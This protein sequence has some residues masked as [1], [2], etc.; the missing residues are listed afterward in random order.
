MTKKYDVKT[1]VSAKLGP[2]GLWG[3]VNTKL[4]A[5]SHCVG[6]KTMQRRA[7]PPALRLPGLA[8]ADLT[9]GTDAESPVDVRALATTPLPP[10]AG[11]GRESRKLELPPLSGTTTTSPSTT[12]TTTT[13]LTQNEIK[14][15]QN[16]KSAKRFREAQKRRWQLL[17]SELERQKR[18]VEELRAALAA[19]EGKERVSITSLT[20]TVGGSNTNGNGGNDGINMTSADRVVEAEAAL[21]AQLLC[22]AAPV[23]GRPY[24][25]ELGQLHRCVLA[26]RDGVVRSTRRGAP[27]P[28]G[29]HLVHDVSALDAA[30]VRN[31]LACADAV[32]IGYVRSGTRYN[33]VV[34]PVPGSNDVLL[35][36]FMPFRRPL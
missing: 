33:A 12:I 8:P 18:L 1:D 9:L 28:T 27:L 34:K 24:V 36:E 6:G 32:A 3:I 17:N 20:G 5:L 26:G 16:R 2:K 21:Y 31:A 35:A 22:S 19:G 4:G 7:P 23:G 11:S 30:S 29:S 13:A 25:A 14:K 10:S 15:A